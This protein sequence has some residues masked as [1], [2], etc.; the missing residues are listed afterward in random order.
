MLEQQDWITYAPHILTEW[1][2]CLAEGRDVEQY[3]QLVIDIHNL[4]G[5][6][7]ALAV[8]AG[9]LLL[10]APIREDFHYVEPSDL[11]GIRAE[12]QKNQPVFENNL[13]EAEWRDKLQGA[14]IGRIAGCLLGKPIEGIRYANL[15]DILQTTGNYPMTRYI[16]SDQFTDELC[17]RS[18][19]PLRDGRCWADNV[20][21]IEPI[22]DDTNYPVLALRIM[23]NYGWNFRPADVLEA[24]MTY[25]PYL[26]VCTAE[27]ICYRN[28][29][30][31]MLPPETA[32]WRN[33]FRE[34]VGARIRGDFFGFVTPGEPELAAELGWRDA[35]ISHVKNGIYGEMYVCAMIAAAAVCDDIE[36]IIEAGLAQV[37]EHSR[38]YESMRQVI[39][40]Y[41][42][43][44]S[45][46]EAIEKIH[47]IHRE[48]L[49]S[50]WCDTI[51][52][53]MIVTMGLLYGEGDFGR[54]IGLA[55]QA[56]FDTDCN[57]ATVGSIIGIR[58]GKKGIDPYWIAPWQERL[59]T[60]ILDYSEVTVDTLVE[61]TLEIMAKREQK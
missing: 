6:K 49:F 3:K 27:R 44:V 50:G 17:E 51:S 37:P 43:G 25:D 10:N 23:Q 36:T 58:N 40:W 45:A 29:A 12:R 5:N 57:G 8:E 52:N 1:E 19:W 26:Q 48:D 18:A 39:S 38:H 2:A 54:S 35:T 11:E 24:W 56:A 20:K 22:D 46:E 15:K 9:K 4:Q 31:G 42:S 61:K 30:M 16:T 59:H 28:A 41:K 34:M 14:W 13:S 60:A 47:E 7:E 33:P 53:D 55:V 32:T 21:G